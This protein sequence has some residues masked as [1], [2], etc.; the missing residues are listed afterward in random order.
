MG[1]PRHDTCQG[2]VRIRLPG[3][4]DRS[5]ETP[6]GKGCTTARYAYGEASQRLAET[7]NAPGPEGK[8]S[9]EGG[10][11]SYHAFDSAYRLA[12]PGTEYEVF[13]GGT[14][15][16]AADSGGHAL[17]TSY[18]S[19]GEI[20]SQKQ[21][22]KTVTYQ[23]DP[24][25]RPLATVS[26]GEGNTQA[27][28]SHYAGEGAGAA[29]TES[30]GNFSRNI[31]GVDGALAAIQT[32]S[33]VNLQISNLHGD[34]VGT[35]ADTSGASPSLQSEPTAFGVPT[36]STSTHG[37][38]GAAG[39][40][41]TFESGVTTT[42]ASVYVP[43]VAVHIEEEAVDYSAIQDPVDE[44]QAHLTEVTQG[45]ITWTLPGALQPGPVNLQI[46]NEFWSDPPWNKSAE[47]EGTAEEEGEEGAATIARRKPFT[48]EDVG[49]VCKFKGVVLTEAGIATFTIQYQCN[50]LVLLSAFA[51]VGKVVSVDT[52][53][54]NG[55]TKGGIFQLAVLNPESE[56]GLGGEGI[57][58]DILWENGLKP[59]TTVKCF[60][61]YIK[62][63]S[64]GSG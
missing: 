10:N 11:T 26:E 16:A 28:T 41:L 15:I 49:G 32:A 48:G 45:A 12:D 7:T 22:A 13:G 59:K 21:N 23:R 9:H 24:D 38:L 61:S 39:S 18:Y 14:T 58:V 64:R 6:T 34:I 63:E 27:V 55:F 53:E 36:G 46:M 17:E 57:C 1:A 56:L 19:S 42:S 4:A 54:S 33:G 29:W 5:Q 37:W 8:C 31:A 20:Y 51:Y 3:P 50:T 2:H 43:Q 60:S 25:G 30:T 35:V 44:Y 62:R 47:L 52:Y 40:E